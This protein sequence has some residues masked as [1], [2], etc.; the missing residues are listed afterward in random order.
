MSD[1]A[2]IDVLT[3]DLSDL[4]QEIYAER[5]FDVVDDFGHDMTVNAVISKRVPVGGDGITEQFMTGYTDTVRGS[6]NVNANFPGTNKYVVDKIKYRWSE[7]NPA[8]ND[9]LSLK[10]RSELHYLDLKRTASAG[11]GAIIELVEKIATDHRRDYERNMGLLRYSPRSGVIANV[12]GVLVQN[13]AKTWASGTA[14]SSGAGIRFRVDNGS[15][16]HFWPG[17]RLTVTKSDGTGSFNC[18]VLGVNAQDF[19]VSVTADA[20][21]SSNTYDNGLIYV[22]GQ[23]GQGCYSLREWSSAG[24]SGFAGGVD[25]SSP[26]FQ[27]WLTFTEIDAGSN[28]FSRDLMDS[29]SQD[30]ELGVADRSEGSIVS[31][32]T[33]RFHNFR[34]ALGNDSFTV[35]QGNEQVNKTFGS[36]TL[37]YFHPDYDA[38]TIKS[39]KYQNPSDVYWLA[40]AT[41]RSYLY[42]GMGVEIVESFYRKETD[43]AGGSGRGLIY[44]MDT[45]LLGFMDSCIHPKANG[46][47]RNVSA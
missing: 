21:V 43:Q 32:H 1:R 44:A 4:M 38:I 28:V 11:G 24:A 3:S 23:V 13:N 17:R 25:R 9:F 20:S 40:P 37:T 42:G 31:M 41:W 7:S 5:L 39:D 22:E 45:A 36:K 15:V 14:F 18:I 46:V 35:S 2:N 6:T 34:N 33:T 26:E 27:D 16:N 8:L 30:I 12:N 47:W 19:S 10:G 29:M